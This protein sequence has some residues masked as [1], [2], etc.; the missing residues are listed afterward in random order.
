MSTATFEKQVLDTLSNLEEE[1]TS[2][3][4]GLDI[5]KEKIIDDTILSDDDKHAIDEA[6]QAEKEGKLLSKRKVFS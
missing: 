2:V 3:K 4:Q 1:I 5:I 6:L